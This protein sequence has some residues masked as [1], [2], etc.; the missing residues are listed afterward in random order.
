MTKI[1][2]GEERQE[3]YAAAHRRKPVVPSF[4][5]AFKNA[6]KKAL[7]MFTWKGKE[8]NTMNKGDNIQD[9]ENSH[10]DFAKF[11]AGNMMDRSKAGW[12]SGFKAAAPVF[13]TPDNG[14][15]GTPIGSVSMIPEVGSVL[16]NNTPPVLPPSVDNMTFNRR[17]IRHI[18]NGI[19]ATDVKS[20]VNGIIGMKDNGNDLK[21]QI[22]Q[23][24]G[25]TPAMD[26]QQQQKMLYNTF[27]NNNISGSLGANDRRRFREWLNPA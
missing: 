16:N 3:R 26:Q 27:A 9:F 20:L 17:D 25:I 6:Q 7:G 23:K 21:A 8:Y 5:A 22:Y 1:L 10:P 11:M 19:G 24:A 14:Q 12:G 15:P 2:T 4:Q 18:F 13:Q